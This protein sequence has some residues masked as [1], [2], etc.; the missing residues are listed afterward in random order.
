MVSTVSWKSTWA[1]SIPRGKQPVRIGRE[2]AWARVCVGV[3]SGE[4][5]EEDLLYKHQGVLM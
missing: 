3:R 2:F 1:R 5:T 4:G